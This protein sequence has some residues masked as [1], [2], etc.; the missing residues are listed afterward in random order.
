MENYIF[1]IKSV[2]DFLWFDVNI[3][4]MAIEKCQALYYAKYDGK[5]NLTLFS[6]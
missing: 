6:F 2:I 3:K 4:Y 1:A 5:Y